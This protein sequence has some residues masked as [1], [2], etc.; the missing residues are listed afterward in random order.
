MI[1]GK[2]PSQPPP[3]TKTKHAKQGRKNATN[4]NGSQRKI[5]PICCPTWTWKHSSERRKTA[6][7]LFSNFAIAVQ[8][9]IQQSYRRPTRPPWPIISLPSLRHTLL[10]SGRVLTLHFLFLAPPRF[11]YPPHQT[12]F[13]H[14]FHLVRHWFNFRQTIRKARRHPFSWGCHWCLS[15]AS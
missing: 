8:N 13:Q 5:N 10:W 4:G 3:K 9:R 2:R 12:Y 1:Y 15:S 14:G 11:F 6:T 7:G